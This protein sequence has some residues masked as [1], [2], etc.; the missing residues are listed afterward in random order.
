MIQPITIEQIQ[1]EGFRAYLQPQTIELENGKTP[2]SL[3]IFA[4][5][6]KGKSSLIDA[7]EYYFSSDGTLKRLGRRAAQTQAGPSAL[8][9]V[10]AEK[11]GIAPKSISGFGEEQRGSTQRDC[12]LTP[13]QTRRQRFFR[14]RR[15]HSSFV[16]SNCGDLWKTRAQATNIRN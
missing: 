11:T 14:L 2:R 5:N 16:V 1:I 8:E 9:H 6:A 7:F 13:S 12:N 15:S 3:A 10:D 4:P